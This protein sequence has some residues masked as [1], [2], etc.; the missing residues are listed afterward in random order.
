MN[1]VAGTSNHP[2]VPLSLGVQWIMM[3]LLIVFGSTAPE[4]FDPSFGFCNFFASASAV[5][6]HVAFDTPANLKPPKNEVIS[7]RATTYISS[8]Y[9]SL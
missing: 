9:G 5:L 4:F 7:A 2:R 3:L 8:G 6:S 1:L